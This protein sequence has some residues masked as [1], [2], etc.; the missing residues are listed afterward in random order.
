MLP[1]VSLLREFRSG[2]LLLDSRDRYSAEFLT[3]TFDSLS[4]KIAEL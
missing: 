1:S 2:T 4:P 3:A